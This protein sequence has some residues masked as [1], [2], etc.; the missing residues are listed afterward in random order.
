MEVTVTTQ[1]IQDFK[2]SWY[3]TGFEAGKLE[4][5]R[6]NF[7][8]FEVLLK[9]LGGKCTVTPSELIEAG[10]SVI[11]TTT[12]MKTGNLEILIK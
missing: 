12:D 7:A 1:Q 3:E 9:K 10:K 5:Y 2:D 8:T 6:K 4:E 11:E